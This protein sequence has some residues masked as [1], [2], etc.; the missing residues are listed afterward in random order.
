MLS[1]SSLPTSKHSQVQLN[2]VI[3]SNS[4]NNANCPD[5]FDLNIE[6]PEL[7]KFL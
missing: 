4:I 5:V 2:P 1:V 3:F 7:I 6:Y